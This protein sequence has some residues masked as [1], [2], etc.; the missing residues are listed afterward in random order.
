MWNTNFINGII[1]EHFINPINNSQSSIKDE[2][3]LDVSIK[4]QKL[5]S[6]FLTQSY[7]SQMLSRVAKRPDEPWKLLET[8]LNLGEI[9]NIPCKKYKKWSKIK[10]KSDSVSNEML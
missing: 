5:L 6:L 2:T 3:R 10:L 7:F 9:R 4:F 8:S 1:F